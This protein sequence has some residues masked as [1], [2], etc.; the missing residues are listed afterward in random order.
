MS[1]PAHVPAILQ[2]PRRVRYLKIIAVFKIFKG[3]LLFLLGFF[4]PLFKQSTGLA[5]SDFGLGGRSTFA[6]SQ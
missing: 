3:V 4:A 1:D 5:R 2:E 6:R